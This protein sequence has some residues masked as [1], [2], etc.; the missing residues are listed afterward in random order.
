[1]PAPQTQRRPSGSGGPA[2]P[3]AVNPL[4]ASVIALSVVIIGVEALFS[5]ADRGLLGGA[6]GFGLREQAI[7]DYAFFGEAMAWMLQNGSFPPDLVARFVTYPLLHLS[8]T[9]A[10]FVCVFVLA[11]GKMVGEALGNAAVLAI[12]FGAAVGGA[13][14]YGLLFPSAF[15]L[16]GGFP[17]VYGLIGG[18][19]FLLW[20]QAQ[21]LRQNQLTAFRLVAILLG[22][23]LVFGLLF[24]PRP[25]WV[26]DLA[27][28]VTGFLLS[29][30][31]VPGG[32]ARLRAA[33][34]R[35]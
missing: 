11:M 9:H 3:G 27:G 18:Y 32:W 2:G 33:L 21:A 24:G 26:A 28:F 17:G 29:F 5:L 12:F 15:P 20:V 19:S 6:S 4:P 8:F 22:I 14:V 30:A 10:L 13:L 31:F 35:R 23:Q 16:V 7:R 1:M 25:D 34:R